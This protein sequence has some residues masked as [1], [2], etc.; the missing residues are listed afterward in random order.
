MEDRWKKLVMLCGCNRNR[1]FPLGTGASKMRF[2]A[3]HNPVRGSLVL[4]IPF[5]GAH[6][7]KVSSGF[8]KPPVRETE[9]KAIGAGIPVLF[10]S[11]TEPKA[12]G[13]GKLKGKFVS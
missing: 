13:A 8:G 12:I 7:P 9:P 4:L 6:E 1:M 5:C 11:Q 3:K 10:D 2:R